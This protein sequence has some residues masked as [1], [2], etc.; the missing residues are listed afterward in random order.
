MPRPT[1]ITLAMLPAMMVARAWDIFSSRSDRKIRPPSNGIA[2]SRLNSPSIR[3]TMPRYQ[4]TIQ[5]DGAV[6]GTIAVRPEDARHD[7]AD[8]GSGDADD[9][10]RPALPRHLF[11]LS[12]PAQEPERDPPHLHTK[13]L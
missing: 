7:E 3:L 4:T 11:E 6:R 13:A 9:G 10:L 8:D 12:H 1:A 5:A 2:G